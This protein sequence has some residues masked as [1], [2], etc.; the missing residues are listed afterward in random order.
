MPDSAPPDLD[1][2]YYAAASA[3]GIDQDLLDLMNEQFRLL[4]NLHG[5][6]PLMI[7]AAVMDLEG[8]IHSFAGAHPSRKPSDETIESFWQQFRTAAGRNEIIA[9]GVFFHGCHGPGRGALSVSPA[10]SEGDADCLV[11]LL[12]H[13]QGQA[14]ACVV[15]YTK[16]SGDWRWHYAPPYYVLKWPAIFVDERGGALSQNSVRK[17]EYPRRP[18]SASDQ[19][20]HPELVTLLESQF[21]LLASLM[22]YDSL[23]PV[24]AVMKPTGEIQGWLLMKGEAGECGQM[25]A[26]DSD[27]IVI[28][29]AGDAEETPI[30]AIAYFVN[31][32]RAAADA[33]EIVASANFFHAVYD[34]ELAKRGILPA[35]LGEEPDCIVAQLDHRLSQAV[36]TVIRYSRGNDGEWQF[37]PAEHHPNYPLVFN[38]GGQS[39]HEYLSVRRDEEQRIHNIRTG[40]AGDQSPPNRAMTSLAMFRNA[41]TAPDAPGQPSK[42]AELLAQSIQSVCAAGG[43]DAAEIEA[44]GP[45]VTMILSTTVAWEAVVVGPDAYQFYPGFVRD[46]SITWAN[47]WVAEDYTLEKFLEVLAEELAKAGK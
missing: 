14:V 1:S 16:S 19:G 4:K 6:S 47:M 8:K 33:G 22:R 46:D 27:P 10:N 2:Q 43:W 23:A 9:C 25:E 32:L 45:W 13:R 34:P 15:Q 3:R 20:T 37:S 41:M 39:Y 29:A 26:D 17:P 24:V 28:F 31:K 38:E 36:S 11:A 30:S 7:L 40:T 18:A 35:G 12:E 42:I 5:D 44:C 21:E